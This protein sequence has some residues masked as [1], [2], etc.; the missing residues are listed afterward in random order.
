MAVNGLLLS[1][2]GAYTVGLERGYI[3]F[4]GTVAAFRKS[5]LSLCSLLDL[6][7]LPALDYYA[8]FIMT[9]IRDGSC[10]KM[11]AGEGSA[12]ASL[13]LVEGF[14][15]GGGTA[16]EFESHAV[17]FLMAQALL[18]H[19]GDI[20]AGDAAAALRYALAYLYVVGSGLVSEAAGLE[21]G[22]VERGLHEVGIGIGFGLVVVRHAFRPLRG[23]EVGAKGAD[24]DEAVYFVLH[25]EIN[26]FF[27]TEAVYKVG[28]VLA[29]MCARASG[30]NDGIYALIGMAKVFFQIG[31][32]GFYL[33]PAQGLDLLLLAQHGDGLLWGVLEFLYE[34][35]AY[36]SIGPDDE[37][38][39]DD[40]VFLWMRKDFRLVK[41]VV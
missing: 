30:K 24:H 3:G 32:D 1:P 16:E 41:R 11:T 4:A 18:G 26:G 6:W 9:S 21:D 19:R 5:L 33:L 8:T 12:P 23:G 31:K 15:Y 14:V 22:V 28:F 35:V 37:Y 27:G 29:R 7:H 25:G 38:F 20:V 40:V 39:H 17:G 2:C 13:E 36:F 34:S 10:W